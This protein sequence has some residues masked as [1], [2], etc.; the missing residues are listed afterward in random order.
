MKSPVIT[1][2]LL[3]LGV[4][5][6]SFNG[7]HPAD[8]TK[9]RE[10]ELKDTIQIHNGPFSRDEVS[11]GSMRRGSFDETAYTIKFNQKGHLDI[12]GV[13]GCRWKHQNE[14]T[15]FRCTANIMR[16]GDTV[17]ISISS[18]FNHM[19]LISLNGQGEVNELSPD[20]Q[21]EFLP[22]TL[23]DSICPVLISEG[24]FPSIVALPRG[25]NTDELYRPVHPEK[26]VG[27]FSCLSIR[28][29]TGRIS[30]LKPGDYVLVGGD[31]MKLN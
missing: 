16:R 29:M 7:K 18:I 23:K 31:S 21:I 17:S 30:Y 22:V 6:L 13:K 24:T 15:M 2:T 8:N 28:E 11:S 3:T 10:I 4:C 25:A 27:I 12:S 26:S 19:Y 1:I 14:L 9:Y 20:L 5:L